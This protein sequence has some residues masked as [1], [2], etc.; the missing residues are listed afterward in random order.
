MK[1]QAGTGVTQ[2]QATEHLEPPEA[3]RG[4]RDPEPRQEVWPD[5]T[6]TGGF[7]LQT[8]KGRG[9]PQLPDTRV[10]VIY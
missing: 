6:C 8:W 9:F 1:A 5:R 4:R 7:W 3:A 2:P 10:V